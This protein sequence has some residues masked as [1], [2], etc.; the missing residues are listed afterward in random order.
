MK[1]TDVVMFNGASNLQLGG[2]LFKINFPRLTF[3]HG[4]EHTLSLCFNDVSKTPALNHMITDHKAIYNLFGSHIY[5][6]PNY[7]FK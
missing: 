3:M 6:K 4:V 7:I 2:E 5:H 1:I